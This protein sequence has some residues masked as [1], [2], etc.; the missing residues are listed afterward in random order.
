M[1]L[2]DFVRLDPLHDG[3][4]AGGRVIGLAGAGR[5]V[6]DL[7]ELV[8]GSGCV[9]VRSWQQIHGR[10]IGDRLGEGLVRGAANSGKANRRR[11]AAKAPA[12][13]SPTTRVSDRSDVTACV[14]VS[15][16]DPDPSPL[17]CPRAD[18]D[19]IAAFGFV[20]PAALLGLRGTS[21]SSG[22]RA[23]PGPLW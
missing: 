3:H 14:V 22:R 20:K 12:S 8:D 11:V 17:I 13:C 23:S 16:H 10:R 21:S 5:A 19:D 7:V 18:K 15:V 2:G 9:E 6:E 4:G 1:F